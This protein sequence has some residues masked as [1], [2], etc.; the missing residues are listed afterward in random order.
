MVVALSHECQRTKG[1][2]VSTLDPYP[3]REVSAVYPHN[4][5]QAKITTI[6]QDGYTRGSA[7]ARFTLDRDRERNR[8]TG[9]N[10]KPGSGFYSEFTRYHCACDRT[11]STE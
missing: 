11:N 7:V 5:P 6:R 10:L 4:N 1:K 8:R 2:A 9:S 3:E